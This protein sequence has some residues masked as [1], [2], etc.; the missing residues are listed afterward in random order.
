MLVTVTVWSDN[1]NKG[2][3]SSIVFYHLKSRLKKKKD[4]KKE[5]EEHNKRRNE[6]RCLIEVVQN[7]F[8]RVRNYL[9][10]VDI[11]TYF[12]THLLK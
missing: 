10:L 3:A 6:L 4:E 2:V 11:Q 1:Y 12:L 9:P 8:L 7:M 5:E